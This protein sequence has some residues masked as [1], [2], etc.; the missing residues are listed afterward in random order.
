M[1]TCTR[2]CLETNRFL[3]S[4]DFL[5]NRAEVA[6]PVIR[7]RGTASHNFPHSSTFFRFRRTL[8]CDG[9]SGSPSLNP[10]PQLAAGTKS[11]ES[12]HDRG[13][14]FCLRLHQRVSSQ[15]LSQK[16]LGPGLVCLAYSFLLRISRY[17]L[18]LDRV[19]S[20]RTLALSVVGP[21]Q[22]N[23]K[24]QT[25]AKCW[26]RSGSPIDGEISPPRVAAF[27]RDNERLPFP[28]HPALC[29]IQKLC[30]AFSEN[31]L[32]RVAVRRHNHLLVRYLTFIVTASDFS[33]NPQPRD[34]GLLMLPRCCWIL[35]R[36][37]PTP[38]RL[39]RRAWVESTH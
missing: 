31:A 28:L 9:F 36:N 23:A 6:S 33:D 21:N 16:P 22:N 38:F 18:G 39:S 1:H 35:P 15:V 26:S 7:P 20:G 19:R 5:F 25:C 27:V 30:L 29:A 13:L 37:L 14:H 17:L 8:C 11:S 3:G 4:L 12:H 24:T 34:N 32:H 10:T 2:G